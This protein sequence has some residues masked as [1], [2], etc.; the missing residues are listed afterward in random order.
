MQDLIEA[1]FCDAPEIPGAV[2]RF[3]G[4]QPGF[5]EAEREY[6]AAA[7]EIAR[8]VGFQLFDKFESAYLRYT[9]YE[10]N[11]YYRFGLGLR[12]AASERLGL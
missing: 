4:S 9:S 3:C 12:A 7:R 2:A 6:E 10:V 8:A 1:L 11:A 5:A